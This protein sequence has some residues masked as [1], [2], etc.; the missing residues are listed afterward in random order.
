M[1]A[2]GVRITNIQRAD[3]LEMAMTLIR[4]GKGFALGAPS[5]A[6]RYHVA[7]VPTLPPASVALNLMC[8]KRVAQVP[9]IQQLKNCLMK[10]I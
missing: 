4:S 1:D 6:K 10:T 3:N 5:F 9:L 2:Y 8:L 7:A